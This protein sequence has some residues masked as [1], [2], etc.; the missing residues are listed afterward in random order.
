MTQFK[1]SMEDILK[2]C[3]PGYQVSNLMGFGTPV[4]VTHFS[5]YD[6]GLAYFIADGQ[7]CVYE[8]DKIHGMMFGPADAA[9]E[10]EEEE[11][12]EA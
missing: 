6:D 9:G 10:L 2:K 1:K 7:V 4:P 8:G 12:D 5:N 11:E 3:P